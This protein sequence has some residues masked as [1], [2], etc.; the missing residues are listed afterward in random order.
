MPPNG[1]KNCHQID[2]TRRFKLRLSVSFRSDPID[3]CVARCIA[4]I[5]AGIA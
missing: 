4:D 1:S 2:D 5:H 3:L